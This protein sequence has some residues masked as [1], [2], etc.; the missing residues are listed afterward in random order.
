MR[1][2]ST[3]GPG[4]TPRWEPLQASSGGMKGA[5]RHWD[6]L[7]HVSGLQPHPGAPVLPGACY[8]LAPSLPGLRLPAPARGIS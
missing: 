8:Q 7:V 3:V 1:V 4:L 2:S 5:L 6:I